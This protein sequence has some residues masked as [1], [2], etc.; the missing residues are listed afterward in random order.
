[1][2]DTHV[3]LACLAE[4]P[5]ISA[6]VGGSCVNARIGALPVPK[7]SSF[8]GRADW[9]TS[10]CAARTAIVGSQFECSWVICTVA[11]RCSS[12]KSNVESDTWRKSP[13][14]VSVRE[15]LDRRDCFRIT[16]HEIWKSRRRL[17]AGG[18]RNS[19]VVD[20]VPRA[21]GARAELCARKA[22][23]LRLVAAALSRKRETSGNL[24][25]K[26]FPRCPARASP[27]P[28]FVAD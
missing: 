5:R 23:N 24:Y 13:K 6:D 28:A 4:K 16:G 1:M 27:S 15:S 25:L 22:T 11:T 17:F 3:A 8:S 26:S 20:P 10:Q 18:G 21:K 2:F 19:L 12:M 9:C 7:P 14:T